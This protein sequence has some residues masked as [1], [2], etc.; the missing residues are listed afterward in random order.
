MKRFSGFL[1]IFFMLIC[2]ISVG[3][4]TYEVI[5]PNNA[6]SNINEVIVQEQVPI[7]KRK[8]IT[9]RKINKELGGLRAQ[10]N[11]L[12]VQINDLIALRIL[13]RTAAEEVALADPLGGGIE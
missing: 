12:N 9:I 1:I 7:V 5:T 10:R 4:Q 13:I 3:A 2:V 11:S 6:V 8:N